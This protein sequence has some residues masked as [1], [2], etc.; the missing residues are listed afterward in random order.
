[1]KNDMRKWGLVLGLTLL[2]APAT[3]AEEPLSYEQRIDQLYGEVHGTGLLMDVFVPK[4]KGNGLGIVD[5]AS[6]SYYSD[7]GKIRDH[8]RGQIYQIFCA[9]GYTVFAIR[10]GSRTRYTVNEMEQHLRLAIRY[11]KEHAA[12]YKFDPARLGIT[13]ASAGG[14]LATL[15]AVTP[16]DGQADAK[17]PLQRHD[18]R[19][20]AAAVFFPPTDFLDWGGKAANLSI[21][22][23]L[24]YLGG[25]KGH[26]EEEIKEGAKAISPVYKAGEATHIPFLFIHGDADPIVPLQ[27]SQKM[28]EAIK[29]AGGSAELIVKKGGGHAWPTLNEEVK[30][31]ADWFDAHLA[32]TKKAD[33]SIQK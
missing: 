28:V 5:V 11:V 29:S 9:R 15:A 22:G 6:G 27:Q 18:T 20:K 3:R 32:E 21:V 33:A 24:I 1:M 13:G 10:P 8:M 7:R 17:N 23:D 30:T 16:E 2:T 25:V 26:S 12:E 14:H 19:V 31:M 4:G